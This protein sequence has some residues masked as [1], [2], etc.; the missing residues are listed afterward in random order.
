MACHRGVGVPDEGPRL[1][2]GIGRSAK[3]SARPPT[4]VGDSTDAA[5]AAQVIHRVLKLSQGL[6]CRRIMDSNAATRGY[7]G[8]SADE[9]NS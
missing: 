6:Y 2:A 5:L 9:S 3:A 8:D 1:L 4:R 7:P